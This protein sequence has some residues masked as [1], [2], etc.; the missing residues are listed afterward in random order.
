MTLSD[1]V[2]NPLYSRLT[3]QQQAFVTAIC[4]NGNDKLAAAKTAWACSDDKSAATMANRALRKPAIAKL[5][6]I[7]FGERVERITREELL[8]HLA[9]RATDANRDDTAF[10]YFELIA[11]IEGWLTKPA[12]ND[13]NGL[14]DAGEGS[15]QSIYDL[16]DEIERKRAQQ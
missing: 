13:E 4:T 14:P 11:K 16:A 7:Y 3:Q 6:G 1:V 10:K 12:E 15:Q 8:G 2:A 9:K 5:V